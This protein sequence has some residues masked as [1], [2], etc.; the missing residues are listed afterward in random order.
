MAEVRS[1]GEQLRERRE[2]LGLSQAQAARELDVARTAYRLWEM[3]AAK[4]S[5]DR[6]RLISRW[7]GVSVATMLLADDLVAEEEAREA[8]VIRANFGPTDPDETVTTESDEYFHREFASIER[9]RSDGR[10][11]DAQ[12]ARLGQLL[13]RVQARTDARARGDWRAAEFVRKLPIDAA[14]P[15][16]ARAAVVVA[17]AGVPE[18]ILVD[19]ELLTS[20][21]VTN[22]VRFGPSDADAVTL[23]ITVNGHVLRVEV[24][25]QA[26]S[27]R[28]TD[29]S[30]GRD[31]DLVVALSSRWGGERSDDAQV[32]WFELDLPD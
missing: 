6:W 4:P 25:E 17:A 7:L 14:A 29:P 20:D 10:V 5:P 13:A 31:L 19:A 16:L 1:L 22:S 27:G 2:A 24:G 11:T 3:E 21:L 26:S 30:G 15:A 32:T 23:R 8:D 9:A 12:A 28:T 18:H